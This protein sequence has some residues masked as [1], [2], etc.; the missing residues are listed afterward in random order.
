MAANDRRA[1]ILAEAWIGDAVLSLYVR[2]QILRDNGKLNSSELERFTSN[3]ALTVF[4]EPSEVEA[5]IGRVYESGGL[6]AA[7]A[8]IETK[9]MPVFRKQEEKRMKTA[10]SSRKP[11]VPS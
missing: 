11:A 3:Q 9:M 8:W 4:G 6:N 2:Q 5:G 7:F 1:K 10:G